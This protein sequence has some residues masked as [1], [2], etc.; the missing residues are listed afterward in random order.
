MLQRIRRRR[1]FLLPKKSVHRL[2]P[3]CNCKT[4]FTLLLSCLGLGTKTAVL[5]GSVVFKCDDSCS[6]QRESQVKWYHNGTALAFSD[7]GV[8]FSTDGRWLSVEP[9]GS[10]SSG[11]Y[12]CEIRT[13]DDTYERHGILRV[14][15][16]QDV[17][18]QCGKFCQTNNSF[19]FE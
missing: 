14:L 12:T 17:S 16:R 6:L 2:I 1:N 8:S 10:R 7:R 15:R 19:L 9:V 3:T 13:K 18:C 4:R 11:T 5:G